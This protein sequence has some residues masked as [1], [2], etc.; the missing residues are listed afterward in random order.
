M[1]KDIATYK[2]K[3][4]YGDYQDK[5]TNTTLFLQN[6]TDLLHTCTDVV[7]NIYYY[8]L[9]QAAKF[10]SFVD[11]TL[12]FLQNLLGSAIRLTSISQLMV[13]LDK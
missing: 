10:N 13:K 6:T 5:I 2:V 9:F 12:A 8:A 1:Y 3:L 11:W 4:H 7:E